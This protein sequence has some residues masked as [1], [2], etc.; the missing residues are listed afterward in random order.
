M[1]ANFVLTGLIMIL[2][3]VYLFR[4]CCLSFV[5]RS[6]NTCKCGEASSPHDAIVGIFWDMCCGEQL[7]PWQV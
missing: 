7:K 1:N 3:E 2:L 5:H 4:S 6:K